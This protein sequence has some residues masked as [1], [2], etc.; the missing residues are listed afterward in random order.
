MMEPAGVARPRPA[1]AQVSALRATAFAVLVMLVLEFALGMAVNL[2]VTIPA[3]DHGLGAA[4]AIGAAIGRGP[5]ALASHAV[6]G[7]L[8]L[9]SAALFLVRAVLA[10]Q[11]LAIVTGGLGLLALLMAAG[12]GAG[13]V[14]SG[15]DGA[16]MAMAAATGVAMLAY[17]VVLFGV[18]A[19]P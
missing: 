17:A 11:A 2:S 5:T 7:L 19:R 12:S 3:A 13:F 10:R 18:G 9:V 1:A 15:A 4:A 16:S 6:L 14:A 8:L